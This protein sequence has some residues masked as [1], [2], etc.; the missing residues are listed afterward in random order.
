MSERQFTLDT[1]VQNLRTDLQLHDASLD[2]SGMHGVVVEDPLRAK[3][4]RLPRRAAEILSSWDLG[5]AGKIVQASGASLMEVRELHL[6]L[7]A[8]RLLVMPSDGLEG[9]HREYSH[10][11]KNLF[12]RILHGYL[13]FRVPL[14]DPTRMLDVLLPFA[15]GLVNRN[16]LY[17]MTLLGMA[18]IYF[19]S[20]Q[21]DKFV[22]SFSAALNL[23]GA[24]TFVFTIVILKMVHELGHGLVARHYRCR[25]PLMGVAFMLLTP[26]LFTEV[27][28]AWKLPNRFHRLHIAAAGVAVELAIASLALFAWAFLPDG[29]MRIAAFFVATSAWMLSVLVNLSPFMRFDGYHMLGDVLGMYNH[30]PRSVALAC[31]KIRKWLL[32]VD[33]DPPEYLPANFTRGLIVFAMGTMLYRL[34]LFT[35]IALLVYHMFPKIV[36]LPLAAVEIVYFIFLP[37]W[38]EVKSWKEYGATALLKSLRV[39]INMAVLLAIFV[40]CLLPLDRSV[41]VP[42]L[43]VAA[44]EILG[45]RSRKCSNC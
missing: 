38:R 4:F 29:T 3:F 6:F 39:Q 13:F 32:D 37:V 41:S 9:L 44:D 40:M 1:S 2:I 26:M 15:R 42:A 14:F 11:D 12:H 21:W 45:F 33:E 23:Q 22:A 30:G 28:D 18:G 17:L 35:G 10:S 36:G 16:V 7:D 24:A 25:V 5:K 43:L 31:W 20:R 8:N 34:S 27:S 19:A